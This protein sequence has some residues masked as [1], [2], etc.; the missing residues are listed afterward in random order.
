M[1]MQNKSKY[2]LHFAFKLAFL[3]I[4]FLSLTFADAVITM[5]NYSITPTTV[6]PGIIGSATV[7]LSNNGNAVANNVYLHYGLIDQTAWTGAS[8]NVGDIPSGASTTVVIPFKIPS[9][10]TAGTYS[11]PFIVYYGSSGTANFVVPVTVSNP[12]NI[13]LSMAN[14]SKSVLVAGEQFNIS[15]IISNPGGDARDLTFSIPSNSSIQFNKVSKYQY[16]FLNS[17]SSVEVILSVLV[18]PG[19]S[20][21]SYSIPLV[22]SYLDPAGETVSESVTLGSITIAELSSIFR[23]GG[24]KL[25]TAQAGSVLKLNLT[26]SNYGSTDEDLSI[27]LGSSSYLIP[28]NSPI[29]YFD[30]LAAGNTNSQIVLVGVSSSASLG[31]Y[32]LPLTVKLSNGQSFDTTI[33]IQVESQSELKVEYSTTP[34]SLAPGSTAELTLDISNIGDSGIRS[35]TITLSSDE[36]QITGETES[37]LG[38]INVDETSVFITNINIPS[39]VS[40][41]AKDILANVTFKD[42]SNQEHTIESHISLDVLSQQSAALTNSTK[43]TFPTNRATASQNNLIFLAIGGVIILVGTYFGYRWWKGKKKKHNA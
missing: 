39:N 43:A 40:P 33:G 13:I 38:T 28:I 6:K 16:P 34:S 20:A 10:Y 30:D 42:S 31:Y 26:I 27:E 19:A 18:N 11:L 37:F 23:I 9:T 36:L 32:S 4:L 17:N 15:L 1:N 22:M 14:T 2:E 25:N 3:S 21:G 29:I 12:P 41:G 8:I 5:S 24:E 35:T 7:I